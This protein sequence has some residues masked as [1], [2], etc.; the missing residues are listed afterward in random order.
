MLELALEQYHTNLFN[1]GI[2]KIDH[3]Q[4]IEDEDATNIGMIKFDVR[5]LAREFA[6]WTVTTL[7]KDTT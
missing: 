3:L 5:M 1:Q 2:K 7:Q 4:D 6:A